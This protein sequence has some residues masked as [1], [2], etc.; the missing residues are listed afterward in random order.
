MSANSNNQMFGFSASDAKCATGSHAMEL[1]MKLV[2]LTISKLPAEKV[3]VGYPSE[4][5]NMV[6][7]FSSCLV[8]FLEWHL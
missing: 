4:L 1:A 7:L 2:Q 8:L 3:Y 5:S 6:S